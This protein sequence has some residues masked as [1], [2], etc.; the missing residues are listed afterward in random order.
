MGRIKQK[1]KEYIKMFAIKRR[2]KDSMKVIKW[3]LR[4][5]FF[6]LLVY[7][8]MTGY[9]WLVTGHPNLA[10]FR[11][12]IVAV[13]GLTVA[14]KFFSEYLVDID[15]DGVPDEAKKGERRLP[16]DPR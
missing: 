8:V 6:C 4:Y 9:E 11:Q 1:I 15:K 12:Y 10:E 16:Y 14:I 13:G 7:L 3:N 2:D 5:L